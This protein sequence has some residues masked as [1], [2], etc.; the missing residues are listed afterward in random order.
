MIINKIQ[1]SQIHLFQIGHSLHIS[2]KDFILLKTLNSE[3]SYIEVW[4]TDECSKP[5]E[6][7]IN[8]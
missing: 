2:P 6:I 1:E 3:L 4:F 8:I 7:N 5:L